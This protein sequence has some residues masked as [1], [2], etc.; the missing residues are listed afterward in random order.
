MRE[1]YLNLYTYD[2]CTRFELPCVVMASGS[3][4]QSTH[5]QHVILST[6]A[7]GEE[8]VAIAIHT[9]MSPQEHFH[10]HL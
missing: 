4:Q 5:G 10:V 7:C 1:Q 6:A 9:T 3:E 2:T 8:I